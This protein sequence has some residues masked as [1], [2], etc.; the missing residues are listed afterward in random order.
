MK[1]VIEIMKMIYYLFAEMY[2]AVMILP[3]S[4]LLVTMFFFFFLI[5][6]RVNFILS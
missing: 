4:W 3:N 5:L 6:R 2:V 1:K